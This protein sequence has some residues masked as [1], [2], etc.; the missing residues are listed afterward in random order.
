M[1]DTKDEL[2]KV[3]KEILD[4]TLTPEEKMLTGSKGGRE[5][6]AVILGSRWLRVF[7]DKIKTFLRLGV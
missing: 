1:S 5:Q 7:I 2:E 6:A 3:G 4:N